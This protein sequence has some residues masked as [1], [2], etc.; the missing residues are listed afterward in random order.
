MPLS[1]QRIALIG[2]TGYGAIHLRALLSDELRERVDFRAAVVINPEEAHGACQKLCDAK[3]KLYS[4]VDDLWAEQAGKIDLCIIPTGI[5]WH[6]SMTRQ[7]LA[8]GANVLLEK[9]AAASLEEVDAM[10]EAEAQ[11]GK[12]VAVGFQ[13]IYRPCLQWAKATILAGDLGQ[14][15]R[16]RAMCLW[17]RPSSYYQRN[18]W[19]GRLRNNIG[20][21]LDSPVNNAMAHFVN[22]GLFLAGAKQ[23]AAARCHSLQA[24]LYRVQDIESFDTVSLRAQLDTGQELSFWG[25]HSSPASIQPVVLLEGSNGNLRWT[26]DDGVTIEVPGEPP[27]RYPPRDVFQT[28]LIID[29]FLDHIEGITAPLCTLPMARAHTELVVRLHRDCEI[30]SVP[31]RYIKTSNLNG[32]I[33]Q[34]IP[35]LN[36]DTQRCFEANLLFGE[37]HLPWASA[38][39][40]PTLGRVDKVH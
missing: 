24:S 14:I 30:E 11:S 31:P 19:A 1:R 5:A 15:Q 4:S 23:H 8:V 18:N 39:L 12:T 32:D 21:V 33:Y 26:Q 34:H 20:W 17:P 6:C 9:P 16:I 7:A 28:T 40:S 3:V 38:E 27:R 13:D 2:I 10:I 25:S 36:A 37:A 22:L 35:S 29:K